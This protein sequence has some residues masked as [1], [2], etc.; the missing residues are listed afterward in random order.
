MSLTA[1]SK[2]IGATAA[3][4]V[5]A[6]ANA[7][8]SQGGQATLSAVITNGASGTVYLG[9]SGVTG[10][11]NGF[12]LAASATVMF[13]LRPFESLYAITATGS[14]TISYLISGA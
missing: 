11:S 13:Q 12:G 1:G 3:T 7:Y 9:G 4:G 2:S 5:Y 8:A 6:A 14:S 10:A